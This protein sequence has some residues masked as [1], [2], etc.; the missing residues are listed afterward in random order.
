L[1]RKLNRNCSADAFLYW[2]ANQLKLGVTMVESTTT[3]AA[4]AVSSFSASTSSILGV[5][6][7]SIQTVDG[8]GL[9]ETEM[10]VSGMH[11]GG[12]GG[13]KTSSFKRCLL[14]KNVGDCKVAHRLVT[15]VEGR[16]SPL[17]YI[18][19]LQ[20]GGAIGDVAAQA[21]AFGC[22]DWHFACVITGVWSRDEDGTAAARAA[23]E[24]VYSVAGGLLPLSSGVYSAD[25]GPDPRD[26]PL[27]SRAF[28]VNRQRLA[29]LKQSLDPRSI[30]AYAC[31]LPTAPPG[32]KLILLIT[33]ESCS[34]KD[35]CA[36]V[37]VSMFAERALTA[38][39]VSISDAIKR[40]YAAA[41]GADPDRLL[42]DRVYKEQH[43][44]ALTAYFLEQVQ[45]DPQLPEEHFSNVVR[46][47]TDADV[48]LITGMRDKAP[49]AALSHLVPSSRLLEV[50]V[51]A[52][53]QIRRFRKG[54]HLGGS[55]GERKQF[56]ERTGTTWKTL[57]HQ[58]DFI[59]DN[60]MTGC[61]AAKDFFRDYLIA[62]VDEDL[63][64]LADMVH[65]TPNFPR[66]NI[67]FRHVLGV[68]QQPGGLAL[69][70]SLLENHFTGNW[71]N[72]AA[73]ACCEVGGIV[74]A[75]ALALRV[76]VPLVLIRK[77]GKLPPPTVSAVKSRSH[78]SS[79]TCCNGTKKRI[80]MERNAM[81]R[82]GSVVVVD[83]VL[84]SGE[85]LCAVLQLLEDAGVASV[86]VLVV[87]EFPVHGGR[88]RLR[89]CGYGKVNVRSLL[90]LSGA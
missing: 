76:N 73:V 45:H 7:E 21:T 60:E 54:C 3:A 72:V 36:D 42:S 19:L 51:Q 48:L 56:S 83:D 80:E 35:Y 70:T 4:S 84:S 59:F 24:W 37:W 41:T 65:L 22:R 82:G 5:E 58:P 32:P 69:C 46:G 90:T 81:P 50:Y 10:Y 77:A 11:G 64:Q 1:A 63:L 14:M 30:L 49:V 74:F 28:G 68:S 9:F 66:P 78:I 39:A 34:G 8:V 16:P 47:A 52:S 38:R 88:E 29:Q 20:G 12:H 18:H 55:D 87:A 62:L 40:E 26:A 57:D 71:S 31:P 89:R 13:G 44:T 17:C 2:D 67:V 33:G 86:N 43:R 27:A 61:E 25:L 85:T 75:S 53:G 23:V 15:A 79:L 6:E